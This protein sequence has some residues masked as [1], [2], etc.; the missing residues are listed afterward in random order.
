MQELRNPIPVAVMMVIAMIAIHPAAVAQQTQADQTVR[1]LMVSVKSDMLD[2]WTGLVKNEV[3]PAL[4]KAGIKSVQTFQTVLGN[5]GEFQIVTPLDKMSVLDLPPVLERALGKEGAAKLNAKLSKSSAASRSYMVTIVGSLSNPA[6]AGKS[7]PVGVYARYRIVPGKA[8]EAEN[9]FKTEVLPQYKKAGV[10][11]SYN[12]RGLG[13]PEAG[14]IV[15]LVRFENF[16]ALEGGPILR[17]SMGAEAFAKLQA[18]T[19]GLVVPIETIVRR[20]RPDLSY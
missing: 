2:E 5:S 4:K 12:R 9:L 7:L 11:V 8:A 16:A 17:R 6:P 3:L 20:N 10:A 15:I 19:V 18:K 13:A 1:V 14:E